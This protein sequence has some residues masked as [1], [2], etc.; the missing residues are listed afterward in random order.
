[1]NFRSCYI[2]C[3]NWLVVI[4]S[5]FSLLFLLSDSGNISNHKLI[6]SLEKLIESC[7]LMQK[8][9]RVCIEAE[10]DDGRDIFVK[11][12]RFYL[13]IFQRTKKPVG[14]CTRLIRYYSSRSV[15]NS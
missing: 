9:C 2:L 5:L 7:F 3:T 15:L 4:L 11:T 12:V 8:S 1:M 6:N 14:M 13:Q 10:T